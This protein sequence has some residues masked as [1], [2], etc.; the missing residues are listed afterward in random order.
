MIKPRSTTSATSLYLQPSIK[1]LFIVILWFTAHAQAAEPP[2]HLTSYGDEI[3]QK[4]LENHII[5]IADQNREMISTIKSVPEWI[6][7][8]DELRQQLKEMIGLQPEP[9]KTDL[10]AIITGTLQ[11]D[12]FR[13]DKLHF[14]SMPGLYVTANF[15]YP[16]DSDSVHP[17]ILYLCGHMSIEVD[18]V[19]YGGKANRQNH[20][21]W[22]ARNGYAV[23]I[24]DTHQRGEVPGIHRGLSNLGHWDWN[25]RGY[26]PLGVEVWNAIRALDYLETR[27]EVDMSR[28]AATGR[29]GGGVYTWY[30]SALDDRISVAAPTSSLADSREDVLHKM[31]TQCD[32]TKFPNLYQWD[33]F[34][35]GTLVAPRPLLISHSDHGQVHAIDGVRRLYREIK[36]V[37]ALFDAEENIQLEVTPGLHEDTPQLRKISFEWMNRW[38][39]NDTSP[40]REDGEYF[41]KPEQLRVFEVGVIPEDQINSEIEHLFHPLAGSPSIPEDERSWL[42][43]KQS[44]KNDLAEKTFRNWPSASEPLHETSAASYVADDLQITEF[45]INSQYSYRFRLWILQLQNKPPEHVVC[46]VV[47][48]DEIDFLFG[49]LSKI[50]SQEQIGVLLGPGAEAVQVSTGNTGVLENAVQ[51]IRTE[52][53][54]Y[55]VIA[56]RGVG[57]TAWQSSSEKN[58]RRKF[59]AMGQTMDGMRVWDVRR[60]VQFIMYND[61]LSN[62]PVELIASDR[63]AG[64]ALHAALFEPTIQKLSLTNLS[65]N[66]LEAPIF[67]GVARILEIPQTVA[68]LLPETQ[69]TLIET[70]PAAFQWTSDLVDKL[71]WPA[72]VLQFR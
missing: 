64:I 44:W 54:A 50:F 16:T 26:T 51:R 48:P 46:H 63:M 24:I 32:C 10:K 62:L 67:F 57:P 21:V 34:T 12:G 5:D 71:G 3:I 20:A 53:I 52:N 13:V 72:N 43:M 27:P 1:I 47:N 2:Q 61:E 36:N 28:V 66:Y 55:V 59:M 19:E 65:E 35:V 31:Y 25:A 42:D 39:K 29:S 18:G 15:Y 38:L 56:P 37:Y 60:T 9:K 23:L 49:G 40:V 7:K 68:M 14:Q 30:L 58:I 8:R 41:F 22:Y 6:K 11:G 4:Y 69:V 17:T 45:E 33:L 70:D